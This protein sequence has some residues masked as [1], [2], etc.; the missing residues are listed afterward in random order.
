MNAKRPQANLAD[1]ILH[2]SEDP[3]R[4]TVGFSGEIQDANERLFACGDDEQKAAGIV[5]EWIQKHQ[6]CLFGR[7]AAKLGLLSYC[8]LTQRDLDSSFEAVEAKIQQARFKWSDDAFEGKRSGFI[9]VVISPEIALARPN[10]A[11]LELAQ[12]TCEI[13]LGREE[14]HP[15]SVY[16]DDINLEY[17][18]YKKKMWRWDVGVNYFS[19]HGDGRWWHDHRIPGGMA[20]SANSVGHMVKSWKVRKG[21]KELDE[22]L[23]ET[24]IEWQN[25][26][27]DSLGRAL[28][29]GM[30]TINGAADTESGKATF[31]LPLNKTRSEPKCPITLP[32]F[33][34][35]K[36]HCGYS[37]Y[38]HTDV[39]L[40]REYFMEDIN[41]PV[42]T[43][44]I[45]LDFTY[46][47]NKTAD[48]PAYKTMGEGR[49]I[50]VDHT[51][52]DERSALLV[53]PHNPKE[54]K[55]HP[56]SVPSR[57]IPRLRRSKSAK[58]GRR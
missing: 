36:D 51:H 48:N 28:E 43:K 16:L 2:L 47:F 38:Y 44:P 4:T 46:L 34:A 50:R 41:R 15:D 55:A 21:I 37:G 20:F 18:G 29:F 13:Y 8:I 14:I 1:Y 39:T 7:I 19:S 12:K 25:S 40:P 10:Q 57:R 42:D 5:S 33:L 17:P 45:A 9:L 23:G 22:L 11:M 53:S 35:S 49:R 6:P 31:L 54:G 26:K 56:E 27:I 24:E 52:G 3:W 32:P 58:R 30:R